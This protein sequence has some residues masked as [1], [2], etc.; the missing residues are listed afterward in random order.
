MPTPI[1]S[2]AN[3]SPRTSSGLKF[4][5]LLMG[6]VF[7]LPGCATHVAHLKDASAVYGAPAIS[8]APKIVVTDLN[9]Q[10]VDKKKVGLIS[11]LSL[12][13]ATPINVVLT[14]RIAARLK[15]EGFNVHKIKIEAPLSGAEIAQTLY[16]QKGR[17]LLSGSL[18]DFFVASSDAVLEKARGRSA[19]HLKIYDHHGEVVFSKNYSGLAEHWIG[20]TGQWGSEKV[21]EDY[22]AIFRRRSV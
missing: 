15:D 18:D 17:L 22:S 7:T 4:F 6:I 1:S 21:L 20:L 5:L 13:S 2:A 14:D 9:G 19:F 11:M 10:R 8:G 16:S 12:E 3:I